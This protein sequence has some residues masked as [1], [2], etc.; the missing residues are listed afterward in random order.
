M[1]NKKIGND[2]EAEL[3]EMLSLYGFWC[4]NLAV[5]SEGQPADVIAARNGKAYLIDCKVCSTNKGF[6]LSR[7]EENQELA[8]TLWKECGISDIFYNIGVIASGCWKIIKAVWGIVSEWFNENIITPVA[9]FFSTMWTNISTWAINAWNGIK[10]VFSTI[11]NW[12]NTNIIQPVGNFFSNLWN[13][14]LEKA[15]IAWEGVKS[16]FSKVA[17]F[18]KDTFQKAWSG[19]VKVFSVAGEIF[20]KIK[21]GIVAAFKVVV[22]GI[23]KGLNSVIAIPFNGINSAL[24]WIKGIEIVGI[25]PFDGLRTISVPQIPL[26][27]EGGFPATGQMFIAREAGP[28]MVGTIGNKS[29]VVNN[30]QIVAGISEGVADA[31]SEQNALLREQNNLLRKLLEKDTIVNAVVGTNDV[32]GGLQRKNRRDGKTVVSVGI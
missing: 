17:T 9:N 21:D 16:V 6:A 13:G 30:E 24:N 4:H 22:N 28:E 26:L 14:F 5:K 12:I 18:F 29:A 11:G 20:V 23:I 10:S 7:M 2:F 27:A 31:N 25:K 3:C 1:S 19:I 15:K 32:I 8:M